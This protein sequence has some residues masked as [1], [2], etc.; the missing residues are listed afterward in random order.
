MIWCFNIFLFVVDL[1]C[2]DF[3]FNS[4]S[5]RLFIYLFHIYVCVIFVS[6]CVWLTQRKIKSTNRHC[7]DHLII[8]NW[9]RKYVNSR[10]KNAFFFFK[11]DRIII[12]VVTLSCTMHFTYTLFLFRC[13][14]AFI[15]IKQRAAWLWSLF[16]YLNFNRTIK[17]IL[18]SL[19]ET[20]N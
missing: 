20:R 15:N 11:E 7:I 14:V 12:T 13:F 2:F 19:I 6:V 8:Y 9:I 4:S 5:V 3:V 10:E 17:R 16:F 1:V 18:R